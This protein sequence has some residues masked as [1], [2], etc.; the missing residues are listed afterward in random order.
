MTENVVRIFD[1]IG[2]KDFTGTGRDRCL[3][4]FGF[5]KSVVG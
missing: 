2:I 5:V 1:P 4:D 3:G